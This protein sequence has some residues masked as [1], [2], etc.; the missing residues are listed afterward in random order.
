[1]KIIILSVLVTLA[2][3]FG[4]GCTAFAVSRSYYGGGGVPFHVRHPDDNYDGICD[5]Y[6]HLVARKLID[7][8]REF[9][10]PSGIECG[11]D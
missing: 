3:L 10:R 11:H 6:P 5:R 7:D 4:F 2:M 8:S 9:N 1:M